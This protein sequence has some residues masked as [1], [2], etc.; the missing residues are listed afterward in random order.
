MADPIYSRECRHPDAPRPPQVRQIAEVRIDA[1][2]LERMLKLPAGHKIIGVVP[3]DTMDF[4][5]PGFRLV[6]EGPDMPLADPR[7]ELARLSLWMNADG[8]AEFKV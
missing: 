1:E 5:Y 7:C 3:V 8:T 4:A 6:V 2:I